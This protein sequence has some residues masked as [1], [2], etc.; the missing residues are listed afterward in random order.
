[1]FSTFSFDLDLDSE[2]PTLSRYF[3]NNIYLC[4]GSCFCW[5]LFDKAAF[6]AGTPTLFPHQPPRSGCWQQCCTNRAVMKRTERERESEREPHHP[7]KPRLFILSRTLSRENF[8]SRCNFCSG[9]FRKWCCQLD[10]R[11]F[12]CSRNPKFC[13]FQN[14]CWSYFSCRYLSLLCSLPDWWKLT[15][16]II[17][18]SLVS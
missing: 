11:S 6:G 15:L 3:C 18:F 7:F 9:T 4:L 12:K 17:T 5:R 10:S 16:H 8:I 2:H 1:M 13:K 14:F